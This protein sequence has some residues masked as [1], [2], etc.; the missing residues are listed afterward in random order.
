MRVYFPLKKIYDYSEKKYFLAIPHNLS[1]KESDENP[2]FMSPYSGSSFKEGV[3]EPTGM[4]HHSLLPFENEMNWVFNQYACMYH[5]EDNLI[6]TAF[7][8]DSK[9]QDGDID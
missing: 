2:S 3:E 5:G 8:I 7:V 1:S 4:S 9:N 6:T